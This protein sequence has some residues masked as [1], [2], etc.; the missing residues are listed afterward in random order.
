MEDDWF[1]F[2]A[3]D[4]AIGPLAFQWDSFLHNMMSQ[5]FAQNTNVAYFLFHWKW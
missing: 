2:I 4:D 3:Q 5:N 1:I